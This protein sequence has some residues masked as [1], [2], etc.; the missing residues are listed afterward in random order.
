LFRE[1]FIPVPNNKSFVSRI[2]YSCF[3]YLIFHFK[4]NLFLFSKTNLSFREQFIPVFNNRF[5][6]Q[7]NIFLFLILTNGRVERHAAQCFRPIAQNLRE[8][9]ICQPSQ[10][11]ASG[12][13]VSCSNELLEILSCLFTFDY[14]HFIYQFYFLYFL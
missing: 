10:I 3:Q 5:S 8:P 11:S 9:R 12:R 14:I 1:Y 6:I 13:C 2:I 7:V 4:N